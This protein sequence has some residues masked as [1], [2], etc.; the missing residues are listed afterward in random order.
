MRDTYAGMSGFIY[1]VANIPLQESIKG[2]PYGVTCANPIQIDECEYV[3]DAYEALQEA[4]NRGL[5]CVQKYQEHSIQ[6]RE[7]IR[8]LI[9]KEY[10]TAQA[11]PEYKLFIEAKFA[12]FL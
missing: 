7:W 11:F 1:S 10:I 12:D 6:K 8:Q 2:I 9:K 4:A 3:P 5:I